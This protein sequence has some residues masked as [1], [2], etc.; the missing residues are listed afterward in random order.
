MD[1][2]YITCARGLAPVLATEIQRLGFEVDRRTAHGVYVPLSLDAVYAINYGSRIATRVLMPLLSFRC[3]DR[4]DLLRQASRLDWMAYVPEGCT[5]AIDATVR[6]PSGQH[7]VFRH[8]L[9]AAQVVKDAICDQYRERTGERPSVQTRDPDVQ[10]HLKI[11]G[12]RAVISI[13]TSGTPLFQRGYRMSGGVA[14]LQESLAAAVLTM[15]G[16]DGTQDLMDPFCGSGTILLE[17]HLMATRTPPGKWRQRWGFMHMPDHDQELFDKVKAHLHAKERSIT[18]RLMGCDI[19]AE[20]VNLSR[21]HAQKVGAD[22]HITLSD[23]VR[24]RPPAA[25]GLVVTNPPY[26]HRLATVPLAHLLTVKCPVYLLS[27]EQ[28]PLP[29][30]PLQSHELTNGG[31]PTWLHSYSAAARA[32]STLSS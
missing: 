27:T 19:S 25:P 31:L 22:L 16:F 6:H 8:T 10:L 29:V 23:C 18:C 20:A 11:D 9:F 4:E 1:F 14:P 26:G 17:A 13:D 3:F 2:L 30:P 15:A 28:S 32:L 12:D 24:Y 7:P 21:A 5:F